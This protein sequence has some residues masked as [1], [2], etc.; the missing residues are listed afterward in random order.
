MNKHEIEQIFNQ[1][2]GTLDIKSAHKE[3][4]LRVVLNGSQ[5]KTM[6]HKRRVVEYLVGAITATVAAAFAIF[7]FFVPSLSPVRISPE[8]IL[9]NA[10]EY[11]ST[12]QK[13]GPVRYQKLVTTSV[14]SFR[15]KTQTISYQVEDIR[16]METGDFRQKTVDGFAK[17]T[18]ANI[19]GKM[20]D[21]EPLKTSEEIEAAQKPAGYD[22]KFFEDVQKYIDDLNN[23]YQNTPSPTSM[24]DGNPAVSEGM[25][26]LLSLVGN[27]VYGTF[28]GKEIVKKLQENSHTKFLGNIQYQGED[29]Y[30]FQSNY[31]LDGQS[32]ILTA[33]F[34]TE[35]YHV[36][37]IVVESIQ[38]DVTTKITTNVEMEYYT[39]DTSLINADGLVYRG[40]VPQEIPVDGATNEGATE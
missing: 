35:D 6:K 36:K 9:A 13:D 3:Q 16:N 12:Q 37:G 10:G 24:N 4:L 33:Y 21:D 14:V 18:W 34:T 32:L 39:K 25:Q 22:P 31:A 19:N 20:Y 38:G 23:K 40:D 27:Q 11:I 2:K 5:E 29:T 28:D 17:N 15:G 7:Y 1:H 30:G 8:K 26:F